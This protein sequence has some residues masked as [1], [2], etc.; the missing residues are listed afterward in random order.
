MK[1]EERE[2]ERDV[3]QRGVGELVRVPAEQVCH[4]FHP[5]AEGQ[6]RGVPWVASGMRA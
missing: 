5:V 6:I 1:G 2:A 3:R 4:V